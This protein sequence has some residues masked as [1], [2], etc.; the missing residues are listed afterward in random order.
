MGTGVIK[1]GQVDSRGRGPRIVCRYHEMQPSAMS[2]MEKPA[3]VPLS[4]SLATR[5]G[6]HRRQS[7]Q[8]DF[9]MSG[10]ASSVGDPEAAPAP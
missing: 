9:P 1:R 4:S 5:S 10:V 6:A 3:A 7:S 2:M 8:P